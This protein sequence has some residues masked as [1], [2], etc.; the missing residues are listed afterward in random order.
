MEEILDLVRQ[1]KLHPDKELINVLLDATDMIKEMVECVASETV[2]DFSRCEDLMRRME[3]IK[4]GQGSKVKGR[5]ETNEETAFA[6][7]PIRPFTDSPIH[8]FRIIFVPSP[9]LLRRGIDPS[10]IINDLKNIG[11]IADIKGLTDNVPALKGG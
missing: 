9:D 6:H 2:F 1:E 4:E 11:H 7:S 5:E 10:I 3:E 8:Q